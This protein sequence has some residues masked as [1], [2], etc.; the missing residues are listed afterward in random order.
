MRIR[1][2]LFALLLG[3][4]CF[5][6]SNSKVLHITVDDGLI[7]GNIHQIAQDER[8]FI[9][10]ATENGLVRYDGF[11]YTVF[12]TNLKSKSCISHNFVNSVSVE[13]GGIVW[14]GTM[15]GVDRYDT[16][17][18]E[19]EHFYFYNALGNINMKPGLQVCPID[20][21]CMVRSDDRALYFCR[22]GNDT[23][24]QYK[25]YESNTFITALDVLDGKQ[26]VAGNKEGQV[27]ISTDR[28]SKLLERNS[29]VTCIKNLKKS[30]MISFSDGTLAVV[31]KDD[32]GK[33][34]ILYVQ[35]PQKNV[36]VTSI[37]ET[38]SSVL[39][40]TRAHGVYE[41]KQNGLLIPNA[42]K[43]L[44]N[45]SCSSLLKDNFGNIWAGHSSGGITVQLAESVDYEETGLF[46]ALNDVKVIS[47]AQTNNYYLVG[48]D[49][50]GLFVYDKRSGAKRVF[51]ASSGLDD[52]V[53][54]LSVDG[55]K[56][57]IGT[58]N[59]GVY[60]LSLTENKFLYLNELR[61]CPE[62][63]VSSVFVDSKKNVW[64]GTYESGVVV[65]N[66]RTHSFDRHYTGY[67]GDAYQTISCNG[68]TSFYED[69]QNNIWLGSY[70]GLTKI[71][72]D[73]AITLYRYND[74]PGMRSSVVTTVRQDLQGKIWFGSL[75]GLSF[76]DE[77]HDTII[78]LQNIASANT[79][80]INDILAQ[81]DSTLL[82]V[83]PKYLY[84]FD[85]RLNKF[86]YIATVKQGEF[87]KNTVSVMDETLLLGTDKGVKELIFPVVTSIK[88]GHSL[89][90]TDVKVQRKSVFSLD[91]EYELEEKDGVYYLNLPYFEKDVS[92]CFSD[93]YFDENRTHDFIYY[94]KGIDSKKNLLQNENSVSYTN[95]QGG[96]YV[97]VAQSLENIEDKIEVHVHI[98]K[99]IWE[100]KLFYVVL[101]VF[102]LT[103]IV[104]V[105]VRRMRMVVRMRNKLQ[106]QMDIR[107]KDIERKKKQIELQNEQIRLQRDA[108]TRQRGDLEKQRFG[109]EKKITLLS[110]KMQKNEELVDDFK[111]KVVTLNKE[112]QSL[113][114]KLDL[115]ED[116]VSDVIFKIALPSETIEYVSPSVQNLTGYEVREFSESLVTVKD[117]LV[118]ED[119]MNWLQ[120]RNL[121]LSGSLPSEVQFY[122]ETKEGEQKSIRQIARYET[123]MQDNIVA[124]ELL[125]MDED[126][127]KSFS[128]EQA[129]AQKKVV[130]E[131]LTEQYDWAGKTILVADADEES[132]SFIKDS[133]KSTHIDILRAF[134]GDQV[135]K[136]C[137]SKLKPIDVI[138]MDVSLPKRNG[139]ETTNVLREKDI[140]IPVIAQTQYGN[141]DAKIQC[142][143]AGCSTYISKPYKATDLQ[144]VILKYLSE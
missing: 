107:I 29:S 94:M 54:S 30:I 67:E 77:V 84:S 143:D 68:I 15:S 132:F 31:S 46:D 91:S 4:Q 1:V 116:N 66:Q 56:V 98:A 9:W 10:I 11:D 108:A 120:Y 79:M 63:N 128:G 26:F 136:I 83:T 144:K 103:V 127:G 100:R 129:S 55:D 140:R 102:I 123:D 59:K 61:Q 111:Q 39:L 90:L 37:V 43:N 99:A 60:C 7:N 47:V 19:F 73:N 115:F 95:L 24:V 17:T 89:Q 139:F 113:K 5:A 58:Y 8:G 112:K 85:T 32:F 12:Q 52:V 57:W 25:E 92:F 141:Y 134:D 114:R 135:L 87:G 80:A 42:A 65:Y 118:T 137:Q 82:I 51:S 101:F 124:L 130:D 23:I 93:F 121:G 49:G 78:A 13:R 76:Y 40:G 53:T 110:E 28:D 71:T 106:K 33:N 62:K 38:E 81:S 20:S 6:T 50:L 117:L 88:D 18:G 119:R 27:F 96:D 97:F 126:S 41:F 133:L 34:S 75:Q 138:L 142:F 86:Q 22:R 122:I 105:F 45:Q 70:Y 74:F 16:K 64:V 131:P 72:K 21:G 36:Y 35:F 109:L 3:I 104:F 14:I 2:L 48:T 69:N 44:R 125:W